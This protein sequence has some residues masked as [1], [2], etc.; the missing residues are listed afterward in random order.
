MVLQILKD[1]F[2]RTSHI[3]RNEENP[4]PVVSLLNSR[5]LDEIAKGGNLCHGG[6]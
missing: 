6:G 3:Q 4:Q 5:L 1:D 2:S